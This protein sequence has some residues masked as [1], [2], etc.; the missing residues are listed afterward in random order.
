MALPYTLGVSGAGAGFTTGATLSNPI[1]WL[2]LGASLLMGLDAQD[3]ANAQ[4]TEA[5]NRETS[6]LMMQRDQKL[7]GER[8]RV[9]A[10]QDAIVEGKLQ[11]MLSAMQETAK[12]Q[13]SAKGQ[14]STKNLIRL[15]KSGELRNDTAMGQKYTDLINAYDTNAEN[16]YKRTRA[17]ID[18]LANEYAK[19]DNTLPLLFNTVFQGM[20]MHQLD[21]REAEIDKVNE[22]NANMV[23]RMLDDIKKQKPTVKLFGGIGG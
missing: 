16:I 14:M 1:G 15:I 5:Y 13:S 20:Q 11:N 19:Q 21:L 4:R 7:Q 17:A 12:V 6:N 9:L 18:R 23:Q 10:E 3:K 8:H 22:N 2:G